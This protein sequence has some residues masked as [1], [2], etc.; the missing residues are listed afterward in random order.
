M[1]WNQVE[2]EKGKQKKERVGE[3][4]R[5]REREWVYVCC[6]EKTRGKK[7]RNVWMKEGKNNIKNKKWQFK[8]AT[9]YFHN[10][11]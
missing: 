10:K 8:N 3:R 11:S 2:K 5:E 4:K 9:Q 6:G 7:K 1:F